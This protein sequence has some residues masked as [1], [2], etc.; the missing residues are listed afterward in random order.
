VTT[1]SGKPWYAVELAT[2]GAFAHDAEHFLTAVAGYSELIRVASSVEDTTEDQEFL[3]QARQELD[4]LVG[5]A[6]RSGTIT[7]AEASVLV[8]DDLDAASWLL[9][10]VHAGARRRQG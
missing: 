10:T 8:G 3:A 4:E 1:S 9:T 2:R 5:S 7:E 6:L